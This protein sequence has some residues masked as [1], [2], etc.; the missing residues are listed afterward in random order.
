MG[1]VLGIKMEIAGEYDCNRALKNK[2]KM[3][4]F[5]SF[6]LFWAHDRVVGRVM[7]HVA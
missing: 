3:A 2:D 7:G 4:S 1:L 5:R 6:F